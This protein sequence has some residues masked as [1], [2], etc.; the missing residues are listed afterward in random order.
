[1]A[2]QTEGSAEPAVT[3]EGEQPKKG[4][5]ASRAERRMQR[6]ERKKGRSTV[7]ASAIISM[8][9][10]A[11]PSREEIEQEAAME[12]NQAVAPS[13]NLL[14]AAV[15]EASSPDEAW[16]VIE[17]KLGQPVQDPDPEI[18]THPVYSG[19]A[20]VYQRLRRHYGRTSPAGSFRR[21]WNPSEGGGLPP[22]LGG[23]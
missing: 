2:N 15:P 23:G 18:P 10:Q 12:F 9:N 21:G 22:I 6:E 14:Q 8:V 3:S 13:L 7:R 17:S 4:R 16:R 20:L 11:P 5:R 19:D 1:M